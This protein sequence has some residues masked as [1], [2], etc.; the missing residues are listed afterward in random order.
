MKA[1]FYYTGMVVWG[2]VCLFWL[3]VFYTVIKAFYLQTLKPSIYNIRFY[4][5]GDSRLKP[6]Y[7]KWRSIYEKKRLRV[8][9]KKRKHFKRFAYW[10]LVRRAWKETHKTIKNNDCR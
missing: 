9:F 3:Y 5:F 4:F 8:H 2:A 1:L 10:S 7:T 6:Y